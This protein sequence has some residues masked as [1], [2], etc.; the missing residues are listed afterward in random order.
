MKR[1]L[2]TAGLL[3]GTVAG[4][5]G[6]VGN[7]VDITVYD[8]VENRT[9]PV[10]RHEG[11]HYVAGTAASRPRASPIRASSGRRPAPKR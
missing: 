1:E 3:I 9:L 10:Y 8:G 11:R 7:L 6:A 2:I 5:A 4:P